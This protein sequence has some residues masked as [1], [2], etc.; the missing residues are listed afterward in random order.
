MNALGALSC[1][2]WLFTPVASIGTVEL[3]P[4]TVEAFNSYITAAEKRLDTQAHSN[5]FLWA[6]GSPAR[7][8]QLKSGQPIAAPFGP[9]ADIDVLD[10][11]IHDWVGAVFI[12]N[13][14]LDRVLATVQDY[15]RHKVLYRP[16]VQDSRTLSHSGNDFSISLRLLKKQVLTVVLDTEHAVHYQRLDA[17]HCYSYS[18]ST[19]IA[20]V[21]N[22]G[23]GSE[24]DMEPGVDHG[25][26]W[27]L[28]SY[29]RFEERDGGVYV[30]CEAIS[31][32]RNVP[33]GLGW[34]VN[35]IVRTLPRE[36]LEST[37]R[38]TRRAFE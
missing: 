14:T 2:F 11:A 15:D 17:K 22:P 25:F 12:P 13:T 36:S 7:I 19:R 31:L 33:I 37:L 10:G 30:E 6:G 23:S 3:K 5:A 28:N 18:R 20:E 21:E 32:T 1:W 4:H 35:P 26:L 29:W 38:N 27:R 9:S 24:Y 34:I 8:A 16:E